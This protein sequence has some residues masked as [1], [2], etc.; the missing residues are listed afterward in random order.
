MVACNMFELG[1]EPV[2]IAASLKVDDQTVR[3]WRRVWQ[4]HGRDGL[5]SKAHP[6]RRALM[7]ED[8]RQALVQMLLKP[9]TENG[10]NKHIWTTSMIAALIEREFKITYHPDRVG[11][12][13]HTLGFTWQKPQR[14]ARERDEQRIQAWRQETWP[15]IK[16]K[17]T[18]KMG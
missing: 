3:R 15:E 13:L 11:V 17:A 1:K 14:R 8:Q 6:G 16:K 7:S 10:F 4:Q 9:P 18:K 12:I 2:D 5:R